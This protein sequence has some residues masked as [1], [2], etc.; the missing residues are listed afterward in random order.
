[1]LDLDADG[2]NWK[3]ELAT[4]SAEPASEVVEAARSHLERML[5]AQASSSSSSQQQ[6]QQQQQHHHPRVPNQICF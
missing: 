1:M 4:R 2:T 5:R 6:Q 3:Q